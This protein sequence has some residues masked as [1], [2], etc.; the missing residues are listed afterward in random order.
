MKNE[1][2]KEMPLMSQSSPTVTIGTNREDIGNE[3]TLEKMSEAKGNAQIGP[4]IVDASDFDLSFRSWFVIGPEPEGKELERYEKLVAEREQLHQ[5]RQSQIE[6][7]LAAKGTVAPFKV[8]RDGEHLI[9]LEGRYDEYVIAQ[10]LN[11]PTPIVELPFATREDARKAFVINIL[12]RP[13]LNEAQRCI[14]VFDQKSAEFSGKGKLNQGTRTDL[15]MNSSESF[16]PFNSTEAMAALADV[17]YQTMSRMVVLLREFNKPE[18]ESYLDKDLLRKYIQNLIEGTMCI[19]QAYRKYKETKDI[20]DLADD[21]SNQELAITSIAGDTSVPVDICDVPQVSNSNTS[22]HISVVSGNTVEYENPCLKDGIANK[23]VCGEN[24]AVMKELPSGCIDLIF[25]S[26]DYNAPKIVYG[27]HEFC[28]PYAEYLQFLDERFIEMARIVAPNGVLAL[29]VGSVRNANAKDREKEYDTPIFSDI[30]QHIRDL[31]LGLKF[32]TH[33]IWDK[34]YSY[35]KRKFISVPEDRQCF[36]THEFILIFSKGDWVLRSD[37]SNVVN[38]LSPAE[39]EEMDTT[40][41]RIPPQSHGKGNHPCPFPEKLVKKVLMRYSLRNSLVADF[42]LGT[43]TVTAVAAQLGRRYFGCDL[44][45][46]YV[47]Q[48]R[49][50]TEKAMAKFQKGLEARRSDRVASPDNGTDG[51]A[52]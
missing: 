37:N 21:A 47:Q 33:Y 25:S 40:V 35:N 4:T 20:K 13:N 17:S 3:K 27:G 29:N 15:N 41:W 7:R 43:G 16:Q 8:W 1:V 19:N 6:T 28:R 38:D 30:I 36:Q 24:L 52:A 23:I 34:N 22:P 49:I 42:W 31:K 10:K 50:R 51:A 32:R 45:P 14:L 26:P 44:V 18:E 48:A 12:S 5:V 46:E 11:L 39:N 9:S 2:S